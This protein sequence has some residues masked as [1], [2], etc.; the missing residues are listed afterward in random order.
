M[1]A[2]LPIAIKVKPLPSILIAV[3]SVGELWSQSWN[4]TRERPKT[5]LSNLELLQPTTT[6]S[7]PAVEHS[8]HYLSFQTE[9]PPTSPMKSKL[10]PMSRPFIPRGDYLPSPLLSP[11]PRRIT[12][13]PHTAEQILGRL[14][15][16][17]SLSRSIY[18]SPH[19]P[20]LQSSPTPS[21]FSS[22]SPSSSSTLDDWST[23]I[24]S[25]LNFFPSQPVFPSE[26]TLFESNTIP[27]HL[28]SLKITLHTEIYSPH[29][30][31]P[32]PSSP[33]Q[34]YSRITLIDTLTSPILHNDTLIW[35]VPHDETREF[36]NRLFYP[37]S[38]HLYP[39]SVE[40]DDSFQYLSG[41]R[42]WCGGFTVC[43][44]SR[45]AVSEDVTR[46]KATLREELSRLEAVEVDVSV[47]EKWTRRGEME[48]GVRGGGG[49]VGHWRDEGGRGVK[50]ELRPEMFI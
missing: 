49:V 33:S 2:H 26:P 4:E 44:S 23:K 6:P 36:D 39:S 1:S 37:L 20:G 15:P 12:L 3:L 31:G 50:R 10:S 14:T 7:Q 32:P 16:D 35:R 40:I 29:P 30:A 25:P 45:R 28:A 43:Y 47:V 8:S 5:T 46:V 18:P 42:F 38:L 22:S 48:G 19:S 11:T 24:S 21:L 9:T 41:G 17:S 13:P 27:P 34:A